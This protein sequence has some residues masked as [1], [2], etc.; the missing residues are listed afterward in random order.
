LKRWKCE[1]KTTKVQQWFSKKQEFCGIAVKKKIKIN[2][3][4]G[5]QKSCSSQSHKTLSV[6]LKEEGEFNNLMQQ[7]INFIFV[8]LWKNYAGD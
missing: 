1:K 4:P 8:E 6:I 5:F 2:I 7:M 3:N